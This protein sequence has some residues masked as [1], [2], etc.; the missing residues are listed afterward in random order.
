MSK[1]HL[2]RYYALH[3]A[4]G[5]FIMNGVGVC[6][7]V[8][9]NRLNSYELCILTSNNSFTSEVNSVTETQAAK[10]VHMVFYK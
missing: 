4:Q 1:F 8:I 10:K 5:A 7:F 9:G 3:G 2:L 6:F